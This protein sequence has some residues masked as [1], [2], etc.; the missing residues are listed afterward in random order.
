MLNKIIIGDNCSLGDYIH[1]TAVK[2][3]SIGSGCLTGRFVLITDNS[4]GKTDMDTLH[5]QPTKRKIVSKGPVHIGNNV[6]IGDKVTILSG[7]TIGDGAVIAA[8]A[9][10]SHDVPPYTVVAGVPAKVISKRHNYE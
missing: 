1:I 9:V 6:W 8:N 4:H 10:V 3:V 7:V 5:I 2:C